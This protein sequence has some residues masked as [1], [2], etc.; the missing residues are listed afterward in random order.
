MPSDD[1][2]VPALRFVDRVTAAGRGGNPA[3][4]LARVVATRHRRVGIAGGGESG[5]GH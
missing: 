4:V 2:G 1:V 3:L 5:H